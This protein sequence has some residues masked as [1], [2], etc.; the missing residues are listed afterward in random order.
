M[1]ASVESVRGSPWDALVG[2][3]LGFLSYPLLPFVLGAETSRTQSWSVIEF[4]ESVLTASCQVNKKKKKNPF[5]IGAGLGTPKD[6]MGGFQIT[7]ALAT[8]S[9]GNC[10]FEIPFSEM[11]CREL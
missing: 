1:A 6:P 4:L 3:C 5:L 10:A 9:K 8:L 7:A 2:S 11:W